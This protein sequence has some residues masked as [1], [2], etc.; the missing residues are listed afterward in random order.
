[1]KLIFNII[2]LFLSASVF[3][4]NIK[5]EIYEKATGTLIGSGV[6]EY[7]V[8]DVILNPYTSRGENVVEKFIELEQGFKI[9]AR[10]FSEPKLTGFGLVAELEEGDFSWEWYKQK[11]GYTFQKL[12][13]KDS[14]VTVRVS[15]L[16]LVAT[17]E[18]VM[19]LDDARLS[20]HR[21]G[22]GKPESHDIIIKKGSVLKFD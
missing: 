5:Y 3:A 18:E 13:G 17:L 7:T 16:P 22:A 8:T 9:G 12:Q 21:G 2:I 10:I 20:F 19:F 15:G 1:M 14:Y 11:K 6:K 4:E